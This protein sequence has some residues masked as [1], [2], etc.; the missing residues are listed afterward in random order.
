IQETV[1]PVSDSDMQT[2]YVV[3]F[4]DVRNE[5]I[6]Q[7][8]IIKNQKIESIGLLAGGLAHDFNNILSGIMGNLYLAKTYL[9]SDDLNNDEMMEI[10]SDME[11]ASERAKHLTM[12]MLTFS[13]GGTP[14]RKNINL[15]NLLYK[16]VNFSLVGT[17]VRCEFDIDD[18]LWNADADEGQIDQVIN[19]LI[20]NAAQAMPDGGTINVSAHNSIIDEESDVPLTPGN[21]IRISV[22]DT[23]TGISQEN[24]KKIFDPYFT[25]KTKGYGIG[26]ASTYSIIKKHYGYI[27][28]DSEEG[29]GTTFTFYLMAGRQETAIHDN[30]DILSRSENME[31]NA[32]IDV[33]IMDDNEAICQTDT[34]L[35]NHFGFNV[36]CAADGDEAIALYTKH[37]QKGKPFDIC[38]LD[39]VIPGK[40]NG[41]KVLA[42]LRAI[43]PNIK[44]ILSSGYSV[45][46]VV[47]DFRDYGFLAALPKPY[48]IEELIDM[49]HDLFK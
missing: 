44:A 20:I 13:K 34:K 28:V 23:G 4:R 36:E 1:V 11:Q 24:L 41:D 19:N 43:D 35:L 18:F 8:E 6:L 26:L 9:S 49:I 17:N 16:S 15:K 37:L 47:A 5:L 3:V 45:D 32:R 2:G 30:S 10:I 7:E 25:T 42:D 38:V 48:R 29:K 31:S 22:A 14:V 12:Q 27:T 39:L 33:L 21:Y 46:P 40:K